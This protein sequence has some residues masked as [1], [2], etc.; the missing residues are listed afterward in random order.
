MPNVPGALKVT[1]DWTIDGDAGAQT[2]F[3]LA[4]TGGPPS[5]TDCATMAANIQTDRVTRFGALLGTNSSMDLVRVLDL[6]SDMGGEGEAGTTADGSRTGGQVAP[7]TS[8]VITKQIGR[9]YRGGHPRSYLP[10]GMSSDI[11]GGL[12]D[13]TFAN[14]CATAWRNFITDCLSDG[15]GCSIQEEI[16]V[17]YVGGGAPRVTPK[18]DSIVTYGA[19]IKIGSQRRRNRKQ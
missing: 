15:V 18:K 7:A 9:H 12:W 13:T 10:L 8:V 1:L 5:A 17:S 19:N 3:H 2:V 11:I 14:D 16:S 4:Y 6:S